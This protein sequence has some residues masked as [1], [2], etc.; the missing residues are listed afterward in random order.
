MSSRFIPFSGPV[1][2][3]LAFF[4]GSL[5]AQ[6]LFV[7]PVKVLGDPAF[8]GTASNPTQI[9]STGPNVV[10]GREFNTPLGSALD[11]SV[12]PPIL[13]VADS[14]NNRVLGFKYATQ[15]VPGSVA[16]F[17]LGQPDRFSNLANGPTISV[18]TTG[19]NAPT[20]VAVDSFGNVYVADTGNNRV[21]RFPKPALQPSGSAQLPDLVLGQSSFGSRTANN[22]GIG[23]KTLSLTA[24]SAFRNG[25]AFDSAGNLWV[26]DT[27]NN[28][29]IRYPASALTA[30][31]SGPAA[32]AVVGQNDF[33]SST[34][35]AALNAKNGLAGPQGIAIDP[36]GRLLVTDS[37]GRVVVYGPSVSGTG[38]VAVRILGIDTSQAG[39]AQVTASQIS[40]NHPVGVVAT[41]AGVVVADTFNHRVLL[42][43]T[44]DQWSSETT[45]YS[46]SAIGVVGQSSYTASM[47]NAGNADASAS[48]FSYPS[49]VTVA[50]SELFV[51][52]FQN[53]RLLVFG[54]GP[55]G[56]TAAATRVVGQLDFP[57]D[58]T[59]LI[60]GKEFS[61]GASTAILDQSSFPP[62]LY[63]ADSL[64]NRI[65]GFKDFSKIGIGLF[66]AD[67]VIGQP[68]FYRNQ[69][70]YP[71]NSAN[72]PSQ[73][74]LHNP[75]ALAVDE[76]GNLYVADTGNS[77]VL[78]FPAPFAS[79]KTA[80]ESADLVV[81]QTSF[82]SIVTDPTAQTMSSPGGIALNANAF[83][84]NPTNAWLVVSDSADNRVLFFQAPFSNGM[85]ATKVLG[86]LTYNNIVAAGGSGGPQLHSPHGVAIDSNDRVLVADTANGRI[87]IF[88]PIA[89]IN[90]YDTPPI[91]VTGVTQPLSIGI[92]S[93]GFWVAGAG[94]A[95]THYPAVSQL[96]IKN[97]QPDG[98][99]ASYGPLSAFV[100]SYSNLLVCD[101]ASRVLYYA[102]SVALVNAANFSARALTPGMLASVFPAS[103]TTN[104][105]SSGTGSNGNSFPLPTLLSD[106]EVLV[107]GT[108]APL[109]F[110][111]PGQ[112][113]FE[114]SNSLS[115]GGTADLQ[116]VRPSTGQ[117]Y[118]GQEIQLA[119]ADPA[120][121]TSNGSGGGQVAALN[122]PDYSVNSSSNPIA[123]GGTIILYGTGVGPVPGAPADGQG[124]PAPV[125]SPNSPQILLGASATSF[126]AASN[127][128]FSGLSSLVGVWQINLTIPSDA[129]TGS[130]VPIKIF[131]NSISSIDPSLSGVGSTTISIK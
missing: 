109:F 77:R 45:Q 18:R 78:R 42:F 40:V 59:N 100:D 117:V 88:N 4:S 64:N 62:H 9:E 83:N 128:S 11:T 84:F 85:S 104:I 67:L 91:S 82:T 96:G 103:G 56:I 46:P 54:F 2:A 22:G 48:S 55:G 93:T 105:L 110:V 52:D 47:S 31:L 114:L 98:T 68:D 127:V 125:A 20:A 106:T 112:I 28:R 17:V 116:V 37:L 89:S 72:T 23:P 26:A 41:T 60:E 27:G 120:L 6:S 19:L 57:Y 129:P 113:N 102:P 5:C 49:D 108:P 63:V 119:S 38:A 33:V 80:L 122:F 43:P 76:N 35:A 12:S 51:T 14:G 1:L 32:D 21:V 81:G 8:V 53:S 15:L 44:V 73:Q 124:S 34:A 7:K 101:S 10:E 115:G 25:L 75:T 74:S 111:S 121:F 92:S 130:S 126:V 24:T 61:F 95:L 3:F 107:N 79:G 87:Q 99:L 90:N 29:V 39:A 66:Q 13:Y 71:T 118:G 50:G 123:R 86:S 58:A 30:G 97:N 70:N 69:I 16:D 36:A 65:L 94:T 131:Q